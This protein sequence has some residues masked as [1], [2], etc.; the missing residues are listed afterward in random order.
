MPSQ[1]PNI[2]CKNAQ[3]MDYEAND[4]ENLEIFGI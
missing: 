1:S 4:I 3:I 2:A